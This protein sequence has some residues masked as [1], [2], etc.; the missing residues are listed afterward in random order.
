MADTTVETGVN[1]QA[2]KSTYWG[3]YWFSVDI[4]L[5]VYI[6]EEDDI[7]ITHTTDRGATWT[8]TEIVIG[9]TRTMAVWYDKETPGD[10]GNKVHIAWLDSDDNTCEYVN[11]DVS[12]ATIG[13]IRSVPP[14]ATPAITISPT[15]NLNRIGITKTKSGNL[16]VAFSTQVEI[17]SCKSSDEFATASTDIAELLETA[18]EE[19]HILMFPAN[20]LDDADACALFWDRSAN[21][22][23]IKMYDDSANTWAET[24]FSGSHIDDNIHINMDGAIRLSDGHLLMV[25][26]SNGD[27]AGDDLKTVDITVDSISSPTII[28][29]TNIFTD[30]GE[31]AQCAIIIDQQNDDVYV[32]YLK[33]GTWQATVDVVFHKSVN[34]MGTWGAEQ[35]Y[36]E[37]AAADFRR[38]HGGRTVTTLGGRVQ[39]AFFNDDLNDLFVNEV[40]DI[41]FTQSLQALTYLKNRFEAITIEVLDS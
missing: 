9:N 32:A 25:Y 3:P 36:S 29:K 4:G 1:N 22:I 27:N 7:S 28:E 6:D 12:D 16:L 19:D 23:S 10:T 38:V 24:E 20:T 17:V 15:P 14:P 2:D 40:N 33:G 21:K 11:V 37:N 35:T 5:I 18:I 8:K 34:Y 31:S 26:H 41:G 30:Q 13:T 39:W